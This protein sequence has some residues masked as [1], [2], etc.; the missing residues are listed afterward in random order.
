MS[1]ALRIGTRRRARRGSGGYRERSRPLRPDGEDRG[2]AAVP[3]DCEEGAVAELAS[4]IRPEE[5]REFLEADLLGVAADPEFKE[6]LRQ[7]LWAL[8]LRGRD[9]R[10]PRT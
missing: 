10:P 6:W 8:L 1:R 2:G 9:A 5:I 4:E 7:H 3:V